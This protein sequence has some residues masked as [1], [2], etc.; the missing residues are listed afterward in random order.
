MGTEN[1]SA[2]TTSNDP[3]IPVILNATNSAGAQI[4]N[5]GKTVNNGENQGVAVPDDDQGTEDTTFDTYRTMIA[6]KDD[7]IKTLLEQTAV[8]QKQIGQ[9]IRNGVV[10]NDGKGGD[11]PAQPGNDI[12]PTAREDYVPLADLGREIGK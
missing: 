8:Y 4:D 11:T 10:I 1:I 12:D 9:L 2:G 5:L 7:L 3:T 6:E